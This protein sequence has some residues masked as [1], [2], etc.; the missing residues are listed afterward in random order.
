MS[1]L[2]QLLLSV[3]VALLVIV[4]GTMGLSAHSART[5]LQ[6]QLETQSENAVTSLALS[7][8]QP[9]NQD[10]VTQSLLM[11]ALFDTGQF[12][13]VRLVSPEGSTLFE[14]EQS[15]EALQSQTPSWFQRLMP[16]PRAT[17]ERAVSN[18]W[19]PLGVVS[20][21]VDNR[22]AQVTL[23]HNSLRL[24]VW[25]LLAGVIWFSFVGWLL[26]WFRRMLEQEV[27][28]QVTRIGTSHEVEARAPAVPELREVATVIQ[29][30]HAR[31][32][33]AEQKQQAR[34]D[35]LELETNSDP[36]TQLPNRK[37]FINELKKALQ[38]QV[39]GHVLL[40]RQRDLLALNQHHS[41]HE[42]DQWLRAVA[43]QLKAALPQ[44]P[45]GQVH[46]ARLNGSD[47]AVLLTGQQGPGVMRCVQQLR[48]L[49][50]SLR[51]DLGENSWSRW[52]FALT[53][54]TSQDSISHVLAR[55]DQG[56]MQAESAGHGDIEYVER[57]RQHDSMLLAGESNWQ[58]LLQS[59]LEAPGALRL[60]HHVVPSV[61][62]TGSDAR[63]EAGLELRDSEGQ[64]LEAPL[65]LPA[66]VRLGY[67][68]AFDLQAIQLA[69]PMLED[70]TGEDVVV[71]ISLPSLEQPDWL[72]R[73]QTQLE[74]AHQHHAPQVL[75]RLVLELDAHAF[76]AAPDAAFAM[77]DVVQRAGMGVALRRLDQA[78]KALMHMASLRL[79]FVKIGGYFA[80]QALQNPGAQHLLEAMIATAQAQQ[81]KVYVTDSVSAAA[82]DWLR[83]KGASLPVVNQ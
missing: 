38:S 19:N 75:Q 44:L 6:E 60:Q 29:S 17:S 35:V 23:W 21:T 34:I 77:T 49:L 13:A 56:L 20:V 41:R 65:F 70:S 76:E 24:L 79:R 18:G 14:R 45:D 55:L 1:L 31:V 58:Q 72:A 52:A 54:Y 83:V 67:S 10:P 36:I 66:A 11:S 25:V 42:I 62:L 82:A 80:E 22:I 3:T 78:P 28:Q 4:A 8:S 27:S 81:A 43:Q 30:T 51:M 40:V 63:K 50:Q 53:A 46:V 12:H 71:R 16:L 33:R 64:W 37:Y 26:R 32:Q 7:L 39:Q 69:L 73:L 61:S 15:L 47:F 2:K 57:L 59:A 68:G 74:A 9:A 5:Y 48:G